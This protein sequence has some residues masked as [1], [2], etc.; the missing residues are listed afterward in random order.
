MATLFNHCCR[1][2]GISSNIT[3][4]EKWGFVGAPLHDPCTIARAET[5]VVYHC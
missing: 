4:D 3:K 1:T 5:G 2:A